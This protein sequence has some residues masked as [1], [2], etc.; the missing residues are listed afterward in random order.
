LSHFDPADPC[1]HQGSRW[2]QSGACFC[3]APGPALQSSAVRRGGGRRGGRSRPGIQSAA[4]PTPTRKGQRPRSAASCL[5]RAW[6]R[7]R[8]N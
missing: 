2:S 6:A 7:A 4:G 8:S 3:G 1:A 5:R